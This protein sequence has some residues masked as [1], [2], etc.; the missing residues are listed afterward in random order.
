MIVGLL[1][2]LLLAGGYFARNYFRSSRQVTTSSAASAPAPSV[3]P[4]APVPTPAGSLE[5]YAVPWG[6][7]K[8]VTSTDGKIR[9]EVNQQTPLNVAV[10]PGEYVV[11]IAS[12]EGQEQWGNVTVDGNGA[13][14]YQVVFQPVN[15][16]EIIRGH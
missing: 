16:Q 5:V 10:P 6:T 11:V 15:V 13:G 12:P 4:S 14:R 8:T 2:V 1:L 9:L 3:Q 7:V